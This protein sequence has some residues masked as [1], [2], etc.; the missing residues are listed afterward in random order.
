M[1]EP[2]ACR[3]LRLMAVPTVDCGALL[4]LQTVLRTARGLDTADAWDTRHASVN[5]TGGADATVREPCATGATESL[6]GAPHAPVISA[7]AAGHPSQDGP[8]GWPGCCGKKPIGRYRSARIRRCAMSD[9]VTAHHLGRKAILY[10]C[11]SSAYQVQHNLESQ[12][13]QYA[14]QARLQHLGWREID[15]VDDDLGRSA[16]G[17]LLPQL[18]LASR[19]SSR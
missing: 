14:M 2:A 9:N 13:L 15:V 10:V 6:S 16:A 1:L 12:R 3:S 17:R 8:A 19:F 18:Q 11:Q 5:D 4:E 7:A